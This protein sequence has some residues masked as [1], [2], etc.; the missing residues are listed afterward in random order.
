M[1]ACEGRIKKLRKALKSY[2]AVGIF[3][4]GGLMEVRLVVGKIHILNT[5]PQILDLS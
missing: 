5:L 3:F 2:P 4:W 1:S